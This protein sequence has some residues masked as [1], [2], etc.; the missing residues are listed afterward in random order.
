MRLESQD[1]D[2]KVHQDTTKFFQIWEAYKQ[3]GMNLHSVHNCVYSAH[4]V[5]TA[6]Y[7]NIH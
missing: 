2:N 3:R 7:G 5:T 1:D 4:A 6:M